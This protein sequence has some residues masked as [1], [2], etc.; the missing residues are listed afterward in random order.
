VGWRGFSLT[1][2][3]RVI[4]VVGM[5]GS[6]KGIVDD[7]AKELKFLVVVMGDVVRE[8]TARRGLESTPENIGKMMLQIR[9]EEG[10]AVVAK[11]CV[12]KVVES[13]SRC[14]LIEGI[15]SLDEVKEFRRNFPSFRLLAVHS[16]PE[17]RFQRLFKRARSDDSASR[18]IFEERDGR[19]LRVGIGAAIALADHVI[20]NEGEI[21]QFK[22][23]IRRFLEPFLRE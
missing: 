14:V 16:S 10:S 20:V 4:G 8:E 15:R 22:A 19:E 12:A 21:E 6:G 17:T 1:V 3:R 18:G 13:E 7:V 2:E 11:R 5:P 9:K 23:E